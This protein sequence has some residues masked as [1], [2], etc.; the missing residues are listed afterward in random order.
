MA[1]SNRP[2][3]Q[4]DGS[5]LGA[6]ALRSALPKELQELLKPG[7]TPERIQHAITWAARADPQVIAE[8]R[9]HGHTVETLADIRNLSLPQVDQVARHFAHRFRR[10]ALLTGALTGLPGGLWALVAAGAD[11]Q[12]T[13]VYAVRMASDVAQSY[14]YDTSLAEEQGH[15]AE[16]LALAAGID[17]MR[18]IGNWL[19]RE[20]LAQVLPDLLGKV[21]IRLSIELTEEQTAKLIGRLIPGVGAIIGGT[22]DYTFLRVASD[23]AMTYY[24]QRYLVEHGLA[25][26]S[27]LPVYALPNAPVSG[28]IV[29]AGAAPPKGLPAPARVAAPA[30]TN[31]TKRHKRSPE[32]FGIYLAIFA[33]FAL[34]I[35]AL[36]CWALG[37]LFFTGL[38]H[39]LAT[40]H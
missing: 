26:A 36:A 31:T 13:A 7:K 23:R 15:L 18:G 39:L 4:T 5:S 10:R 33:V 25:P 8:Y 6:L 40:F 22:I 3:D 11:V 19:A 29:D 32:R 30:P 28:Q 16:V 20:G 37:L 2:S 24:R 1:T 35:T 27:S 12:L 34:L 38:S 17:S 9:A 21:L 14:G